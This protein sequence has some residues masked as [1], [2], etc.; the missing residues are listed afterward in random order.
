[1]DELFGEPVKKEGKQQNPSLAKT[2]KS[3]LS[4]PISVRPDKTAE[5]TS[6]LEERGGREGAGSNFKR[7]TRQDETDAAY[8][9][10]EPEKTQKIEREVESME[11]NFDSMLNV[12]AV[13]QDDKKAAFIAES[14][15][16]RS[17]C[18]ELSEQITN[19]VAADS[20]KFQQYLDVQ[21]RFDRYT[22]NNALLILA[23]RPDAERLGDYGY[24]REQGVFVKRAERQNPVLI[25]EPGKEYE[26]E[27]GSIGTYYNAK[28]LY[29][30]SQTTMSERPQP[31]TAMDER[32]LIRALINNPPASIVTAE[33]DQMPEDKGAIFEPEE[34]CIYVRKGMNAQEIFQCLTPELALAGFADGDPEYDRNE[35][36]FHAYC[37]SYMLCKKYGIDTQAYDFSYA[38]A[39]LEGMEPQEVRAE[40]S[41][42]REAANTIS[43][44][45]AKVFEQNRMNQRQQEQTGQ[46]REE[47]RNRENGPEREIGQN[48]THMQGREPGQP[49]GNWQRR[50]AAQE[51]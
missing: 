2:E 43:S 27:D 26:R 33:P 42:A 24:W 7:E 17:R 41:K 50:E 28:K 22:A 19:E 21:A 25:M 9:A 38:P 47:G 10:A 48:Q 45:M 34:N 49:R 14:K 37:A 23:Q 32:L 51:R 40:L 5:G 1:M 8:A 46:N 6:K 4:E 30:I 16:N 31:Q 35:D 3:R 29:D 15:N 36:A 39:F 44:R 20:G 12:S 11:N 13:P 18:Y